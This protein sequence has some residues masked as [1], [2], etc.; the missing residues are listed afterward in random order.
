MLRG[1]E[2]KKRLVELMCAAERGGDDEILDR[3]F[4]SKI[5]CQPEDWEIRVSKVYSFQ[6]V[7][8]LSPET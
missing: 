8:N 3:I 1:R 5:A 6:A 7:C 4:R 2:I